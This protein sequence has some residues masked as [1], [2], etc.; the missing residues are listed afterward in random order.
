MKRLNLE[1]SRLN[2]WVTDKEEAAKELGLNLADV[3]RLWGKNAKIGINNSD[4][5]SLE[6]NS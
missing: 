2:G 1:A 4:I 5:L 6:Y 3:T